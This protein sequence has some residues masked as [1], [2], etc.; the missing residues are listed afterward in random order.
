MLS[1][2]VSRVVAVEVAVER[3]GRTFWRYEPLDWG[4]REDVFQTSHLHQLMGAD[5]K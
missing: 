1:A 4:G 2:W 5:A 3:S